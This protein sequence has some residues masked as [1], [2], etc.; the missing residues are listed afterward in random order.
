[1]ERKAAGRF[2][3]DPIRFSN[4]VRECGAEPYGSLAHACNLRAQRTLRQIHGIGKQGVS[5]A[6]SGGFSDK[7]SVFFFLTGSRF[8]GMFLSVMWRKV[9]YY[10]LTKKEHFFLDKGVDRTYF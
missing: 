6:S 8:E 10:F 2:V 1:V 9:A 3:R 4:G 7:K 5:P